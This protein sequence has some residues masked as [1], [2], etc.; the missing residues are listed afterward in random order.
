[1]ALDAASTEA[2]RISSKIAPFRQ[3]VWLEIDKIIDQHPDM[4]FFGNGAPAN[5]LMP[6]ARLE[7]GSAE[8]WEEGVKTLSYGE[9][10]GYRPLRELIVR[11]MAELGAP[12]NVDGTMVVN[13]SQEGM[14]IVDRRRETLDRRPTTPKFLYTIPTFQNPTGVTMSL[15]RRQAL[16]ELCR[17]RGILIVEDDPYSAFR[18]DGEPLPPLRALEPNSVY[19]GTFSKTLAPSLR[20]GWISAPEPLFGHLFAVK[21][22]MNISNARLMSRLV[23]HAAKDGFLEAHIAEARDAYRL[24][25]DTLLAAMEEYLP[26]QATWVRPEG[27]FF[28]WIDLP[29]DADTD[30]MLD[31]VAANGA[32]FLPGSW[33]FPGRD[34]KNG[35]RLSFSALPTDRMAEGVRRIGEV[36]ARG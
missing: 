18:Y 25:R 17:E 10:E 6:L 29:E 32:V 28:V 14:D 7:Q 11:Q 35:F 27:G 36:I 4:I 2:P 20:V 30:A 22:V 31:A 9:T 1:M 8:A 23:Y 16:V 19:L 15:A 26:P 13:G 24:R 5:D 12:A 33:F 21:E 3:S 34:R